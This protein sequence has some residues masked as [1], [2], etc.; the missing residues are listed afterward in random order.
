MTMAILAAAVI[1]WFALSFVTKTWTR[2]LVAAVIAGITT[3][4]WQF[5]SMQQVAASQGL[6]PMSPLR[7]GAIAVAGMV[8]VAAAGMGMR[9]LLR[10]SSR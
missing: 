8:V 5:S 1:L 10:K 9:V 6:E 4:W 2:H 3:A 7:F